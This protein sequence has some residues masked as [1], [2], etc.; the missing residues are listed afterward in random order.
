MRIKKEN[1][2]VIFSCILLCILIWI[3]CKYSKKYELFR[4]LFTYNN[5]HPALVPPIPAY[6]S[7]TIQL[8]EFVLHP[9][10]MGISE[11]KY[12][13][14]YYWATIVKDY[15]PLEISNTYGEIDALNKVKNG[16]LDLAN[17]SE[18]Y[19]YEKYKNKKHKNIAVR[20]V[21]SFLIKYLFLIVKMDSSI[22][23]FKD[24]IGKRIGVGR[25]DDTNKFYLNRIM[26]ILYI[27]PSQYTIKYYDSVDSQIMAFLD[28]KIDAFFILSTHPN[29]YL[30]SLSKISFI[31]IL[32]ISADIMYPNNPTFY[33]DAMNKF[34]PY[35]TEA[36]LDSRY[37][38][39]QTAR[40]VYFKTRK[41]H[42]ITLTHKKTPINFIYRFV[43]TILDKYQEIT[44]RLSKGPQFELSPSYSYYGLFATN[45]NNIPIHRGSM[46]YYKET[47][48]VSNNPNNNCI[49]YTGTGF[50]CNNVN[51]LR[52]LGTPNFASDKKGAIHMMTY[53]KNRNT[54]L[55][56]G[57]PMDT[58]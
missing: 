3:Q 7:K 21:F 27:E 13:I 57:Q 37:Y 31:R 54:L 49:Y 42:V 53:N 8:T 39:M 32:P 20:K 55:N 44:F 16:N 29:K 19:L 40:S 28:N 45:E 22:M 30:I 23:T 46:K 11:V 10:R 1:I 9:L 2:L 47:G 6:K 48:F 58:T 51:N 52:L 17:C 18:T 25:T 14:P 33:K 34:L 26:S 12:N 38:T 5:E 4:D 50:K 36:V 15:F 56:I 35:S 41:I 43:K 24:L